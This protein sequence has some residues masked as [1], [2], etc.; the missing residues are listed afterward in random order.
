MDEK[1][2]DQT[3]L[4][5]YKRNVKHESIITLIVSKIHVITLIALCRQRSYIL[6]S[7]KCVKTKVLSHPVHTCIISGREIWFQEL[8]KCDVFVIQHK[9]VDQSVKAVNACRI[10][11]PNFKTKPLSVKMHDIHGK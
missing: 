6:S 5:K 3:L 9:T 7:L 10:P 8:F 4:I 1:C 2:V 11:A